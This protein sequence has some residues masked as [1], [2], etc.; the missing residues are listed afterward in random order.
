MD[1]LRKVTDREEGKSEGH[2]FQFSTAGIFS[3][4]CEIGL[5]FYFILLGYFIL[6]PFYAIY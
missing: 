6:L 1:Q 5:F 2:T 3:T 4:F